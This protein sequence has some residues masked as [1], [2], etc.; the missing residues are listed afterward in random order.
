MKAFLFSDGRPGHEKQS[1]GI[2]QALQRYIDVS[3]QEV[4]VARRHGLAEF[5]SHLRYVFNLGHSR[6]GNIDSDTDLIIGTGSRTHIPM[7]AAAKNNRAK[8]ITCMTPP[9][10]LLG[11]FDVCFIPYHDRP[12]S[13]GNIF[14]TV[15]PPNVSNRSDEHDPSRRLILVG[16]ED[17][18]SHLWD[19]AG[20]TAD[21]LRLV[22]QD[23]M[24]QWM[25]SSSPRTPPHTENLLES[26]SAEFDQ[27]TFLPFSATASGW[28]EGQYRT[29]GWTWVT[30]DSISMVYE[31]LSA[32]CRVGFIPVAWKKATNKFQ[33]SLDYLQDKKLVISLE[34]YLQ[35]GI[36]P[37]SFEA[38]DE[39]D[40][41][42]K[43][44]LR[45]WWPKN[46]P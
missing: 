5:G 29:N 10:H 41:C 27:V 30:A 4:L 14:V 32:G 24:C 6:I 13:T 20:V 42:A 9:A 26:I 23:H 44:I 39:A 22:K 34:R 15:G 19:G 28:L 18:Q 1:W 43:E 38:L 36:E 33:R 45:R 3:V 21:I 40:R 2:I 31:A 8:V 37:D 12:R 11:R 35:G 46:L 16:G 17:N 7:L 25:V